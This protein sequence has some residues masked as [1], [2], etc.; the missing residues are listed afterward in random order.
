MEHEEI[1]SKLTGEDTSEAP[2]YDDL[3][4]NNA[5]RLKSEIRK[6]ADEAILHF[7]QNGPNI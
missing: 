4:K 2:T 6:L 3:L 1:F 7:K 5:E